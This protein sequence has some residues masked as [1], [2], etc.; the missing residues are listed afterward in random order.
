MEGM[1]KVIHGWVENGIH[2]QVK[3]NVHGWVA[4][5]LQWTTESHKTEKGNSLSLNS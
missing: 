5:R 1:L 3:N 4:T 2:G